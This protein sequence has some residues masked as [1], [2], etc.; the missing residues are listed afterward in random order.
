[1]SP[2]PEWG[3]LHC[4]TPKFL[5]GQPIAVIPEDRM[6]CDAERDGPRFEIN[7]DLKF[8]DIHRWVEL[9]DKK[10]WKAVIFSVPFSATF[11]LSLQ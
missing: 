2:D 11:A 10:M 6:T 7:P 4:A 1:V 8:R 9:L 3:K 5:E